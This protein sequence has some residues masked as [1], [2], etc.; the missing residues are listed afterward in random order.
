MKHFL[1]ISGGSIEDEAVTEYLRRETGG[2]RENVG[3]A[4][5][6]RAQGIKV[7]AADS[8]LEF[9]SRNHILPDIAAGDFDS[10]S[11]AVLSE[12]REKEGIVWY[13]LN[14][15]KDDTDTEFAI[16]KALEAGAERITI[17]GG[18]GSRLD[19]VLGNIELLGIG[20]EAGVPIEL[21]DAHNR[22]RMIKTGITLEK[23]K[24]FGKYVSLLPYTDCVEHLFLT[25]FKYPL[26]D[27]CLRGF[28]SLGVSNE[29]VESEAEIRFD[30][31][32]LLV[33]ESRD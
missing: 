14:P 22:I 20:M 13:R 1:I 16:R 24:Q 8:G 4:D 23:E 12:F 33:I 25:G 5:C 6:L 15:E 27:A 30:G 9:C 2:R 18:T 28:C 17:V 3:I 10:V 29:I 11:G 26:A 19:H 21:V 31:G 7:I 32:I